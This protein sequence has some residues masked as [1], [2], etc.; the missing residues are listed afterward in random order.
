MHFNEKKNEKTKLSASLTASKKRI[1]NLTLFLSPQKR[2]TNKHLLSACSILWD[3]GELKNKNH[4][5]DRETK[6]KLILGGKKD[7]DWQ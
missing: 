5:P 1:K 2:F 4:G 3:P 7:E 6:I